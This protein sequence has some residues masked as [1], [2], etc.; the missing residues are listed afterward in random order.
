M[1]KEMAKRLGIST[2]QFETLARQSVFEPVCPLSVSKFQWDAAEADRL[3]A[4]L[5]TDA[6]SVMDEDE[7]WQPLG[8]A[9]RRARLDVSWIIGAI[10]Q[11][12]V[13]DSL[14]LHGGPQF[15]MG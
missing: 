8:I 11:G 3:Y 15:S 1:T 6:T 7:S 2:E 10:R 5:T 4:L 12:I 13:G 14:I 9:A